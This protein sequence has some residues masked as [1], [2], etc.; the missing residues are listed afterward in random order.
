MSAAGATFV[1][2]LSGLVVRFQGLDAALAGEFATQWAPFVTSRD[3]APWLDVHVADAERTILTDRQMRKSITGTLRD[4]GWRFRSD[5]GDLDVDATG[6]ARVRLGRGDGSWRFWA[7]VNLAT[8][9]LAVR[10]P[11]RPGAL[12]HAAG[13]VVD[14]RGF[15]LIGPEG[16]GKSTFARMA[17]VGGAQ[18]ISDDTVILDG[19]TGGLDLL[20][21]PVRAHEATNLARGRWPV[22]A[23]LHARWG[24]EARLEPVGRLATE[25]LLAANLPFL[26]SGWGRDARLDALVPFLAG[27]AP[28]RALTFA[29]DPSFVEV[30]RAASFPPRG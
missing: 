8:A 21:S 23:L 13:V 4:D 14:G 28:H 10:L 3:T 24:L 5:E 1:A 6:P 25:A 2:D 7:L 26:A 20:G 15:V 29:P 27:A 11:S 22:A 9:A 12:L 16:A 17:R 30:L 19:V 18:V